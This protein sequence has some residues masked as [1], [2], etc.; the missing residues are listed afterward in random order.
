LSSGKAG[1]VRFR[2]YRGIPA[3]LCLTAMVLML[4]PVGASATVNGGC[5][6][7]GN[8]TS[9]GSVDLTTEDIWHLQSSDEVSGSATYPTQTFVHVFAFLF[10]IPVPVYSSSGKDTKGSAGPFKVSDYSR[11]TRVFAAGGSSDSCDGAV[12]IVVDDQNAFT[13]VVGLV[14]L[15]LAVIGLIGLLVLMFMG[16]G[17]GGCGSIFFGLLAGLFLG[18]GAAL[19]ATEAGLL[20]PRNV[21]GLVVAGVL[22]IVGGLTPVVRSR[23]G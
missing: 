8:S 17:S 2:R 19:V 11:Y 23:M 14:G 22:T 12:L 16:G 4:S 18:L 7:T 15:G 21:S 10:G 5:K 9:G 3:A 20:D 13:N 1:K 6:V